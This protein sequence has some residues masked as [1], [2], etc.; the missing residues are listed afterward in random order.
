MSKL[1]L[2]AVVLIP[3]VASAALPT[4]DQIKNDSGWVA[5]SKSKTDQGEVAIEMR[6]I[7][8][9]SC[10]RGTMQSNASPDQL[11]GVVGDIPSAKTW[12][13]AGLSASEVL[14]R[15]G[16]TIDYYEMLDVPGW[17]MASDR[18]WFLRGYSEKAEGRATFKWEKLVDGGA[19]KAR[20]DAVKA[21]NPSAIE[22]PVNVGMWEFITSG[23]NTRVRYAVCTDSGGTLPQ[24]L[25]NTATRKTLPDTVADAVREAKRRAGM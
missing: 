5:D 4:W 21:E 23:T 16:T 11:L 22:P 24:M 2:F 9:V 10:F 13:S 8:G 15:A 20:W 6:T 7:E 19:H 17:T 18:F 25:Q 12:S 14:S 1:F 3:S